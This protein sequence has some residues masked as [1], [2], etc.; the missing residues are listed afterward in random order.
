MTEKI[1]LA[2]TSG[3]S[4]AEGRETGPGGLADL[5]GWPLALTLL[6][7]AL[8]L[9]LG[10][11][12]ASAVSAVDLWWTRS[13]YN[14]CFLI[15]PISLYLVWDRR[16]TLAA[17]SPRP[18][19]LGLVVIFGFSLAWIIA[20]S[21]GI[22]E[23]EHFALVGVLEGVV[24]A[25]L[26]RHVFASMI[27]PMA[28]L[29]LMVPTGTM[30]HPVLQ[31][32]AHWLSSTMLALSGIPVY[33]QGFSIEVPTGTYEV[34]E[35][36]SG[37][38]FILA[39]LAL[40]PLYGYMMYDSLRKRFAAIAVMIGIAVLANGVR[41]YG[42]IALAE[43]T[44][45]RIDIIDDHLLYGWGFFA[46]I[47]LLVGY[48]GL[49]FADPERSVEAAPRA[50]TE[51]V[52]RNKMAQGAIAVMI[53][54]AILPLYRIAVLTSTASS[55]TGY[56]DIARFGLEGVRQ[57]DGTWTPDYPYATQMR[58]F[59]GVRQGVEADVFLAG[60]FNPHDASEMI[61]SGNDISGSPIFVH[62]GGFSRRIESANQSIE[63]HFVRL[64]SRS[65]ARLVARARQVDGR[66]VASSLEAKLLQAW[67]TLTWNRAHSG[68][69]LVSVPVRGG[70]EQATDDL[71]MFLE[72]ADVSHLFS[73]AAPEIDKE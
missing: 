35:G 52:A 66:F 61:T 12:S 40:A 45:R 34:V 22:D 3:L 10:L 46:A 42:I 23:G 4:E 53:V 65:G 13:S 71:V 31:A 9:T 62:R 24:L 43:F 59:N 27:L 16:A 56:I 33:V 58:L 6:C 32:A 57:S 54:L 17:M 69:I 19:I 20:R 60:Y 30:L 50:P 37:L 14:H 7:A 70:Y 28:Y 67:A 18:D 26:G 47:L 36:C 68:V 25:V 11:Y 15:L 8:A 5:Q 41:I 72:G 21:A 51:H 38:N 63:W 55:A 73:E 49:R 39:S 48:I 44:D 29:W 1:D 2:K 64:Q